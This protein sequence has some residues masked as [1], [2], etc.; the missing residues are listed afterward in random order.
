MPRIARGLTG[1]V[2]SHITARGNG[3]MKVF[4]DE[5]DYAAFVDLL[6]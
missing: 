2:C 3:R 4:H 5:E 6:P 1:G